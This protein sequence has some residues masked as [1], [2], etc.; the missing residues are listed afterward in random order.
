[1]SAGTGAWG[2]ISGGCSMQRIANRC[3]TM[4]C[5]TRERALCAP[6]SCVRDARCRFAACPTR[7]P[8]HRRAPSP[9]ASP[10][11]TAMVSVAGHLHERARVLCAGACGSQAAQAQATCVGAKKGN[12]YKRCER[13]LC[14][15]CAGTVTTSTGCTYTVASAPPALNTC[16]GAWAVYLK[17]DAD[18]PEGQD[19]GPRTPATCGTPDCTHAISTLTDD[20]VAEMVEGFEVWLVINQQTMSSVYRARQCCHPRCA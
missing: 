17:I 7:L 5:N 20:K 2:I 12:M 16:E 8:F 1:M 14:M 15:P 19:T 13:H 4:Q 9:C 6:A 18:C 3:W 10:M 11:L